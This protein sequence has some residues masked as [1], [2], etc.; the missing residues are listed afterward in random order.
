[1]GLHHQRELIEFAFARPGLHSDFRVYVLSSS[2]LW[3][4]FFYHASYVTRLFPGH[5]VCSR[6]IFSPKARTHFQDSISDHAILVDPLPGQ[7]EETSIDGLLPEISRARNRR[8]GRN[9]QYGIT[10]KTFLRAFKFWQIWIIAR[11]SFPTAAD[12]I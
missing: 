2:P 5:I 12:K 4:S 9:P 7:R 3:L 1:M 10:P 8:I 11:E 6:K